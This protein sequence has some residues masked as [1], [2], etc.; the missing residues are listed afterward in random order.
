MPV[1]ESDRDAGAR[2]RTVAL[3]AL[4]AVPPVV[5]ATV[6]A[7]TGFQ[8]ARGMPGQATAIWPYHSYHDMRWLLVYHNSFLG[9]VG[10]FLLLVAVRGLL[11]G[12][13][14]ALAWPAHL[15]RPSLR[16]LAQRN[17]E[18]AALSAVVVSP[19]AALS[20]AFASIPLIWI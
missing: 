3:V 9:F 16:W 5:E 19:W 1:V 14:V 15:D 2:K 8:A 17:A 11:S 18:V 4:A 7:A 10:E 20:V 12:V 13:L 6:V